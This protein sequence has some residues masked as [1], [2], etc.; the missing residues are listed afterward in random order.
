MAPSLWRWRPAA[1][2][3]FCYLTAKTSKR[4]C[5]IPANIHSGHPRTL[6]P[7][8]ETVAPIVMPVWA[9]QTSKWC[10]HRPG[11]THSVEMWTLLIICNLTRLRP[12]R[13]PTGIICARSSRRWWRVR[14]CSRR[15]CRRWTRSA[16]TFWSCCARS[17]VRA[18]T[19]STTSRT[20]RTWWVWRVSFD[21]IEME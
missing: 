13:V 3:S 20:W 19:L 15:S 9:S 2:R 17:D 14:A 6:W 1:F 12:D 10:P 21:L 11:E 5:A 4:C 18:R 7:R 16:T 8:T